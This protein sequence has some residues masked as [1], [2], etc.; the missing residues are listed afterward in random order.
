MIAKIRKKFHKSLEYDKFLF[1]FFP[2]V[3]TIYDTQ[4]IVEAL[5]DRGF[6]S[7]VQN[8]QD[9][10][11]K[12]IVYPTYRSSE[13]Y[14]WN[15][16]VRW[17]YDD[18]LEREINK[19]LDV[20]CGYGTLSLYYQTITACESYLIDFI[21]DYMSKSLISKFSLNF[22]VSNIE[23]EPIPY[24]GIKYDTIIFTEVLEHLNFHPIP[25]L[26]KISSSLKKGGLLYISTPDAAEWGKLSRFYKDYRKMPLPNEKEF[27]PIDNHIYHYNKDELVEILTQTGLEIDRFDYS[28]GYKYSARHFCVVCR[29]N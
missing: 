9:Y 11:G 8:G 10:S 2:W 5:S 26:Q 13:I 21:P 17:L 12:E 27:Q 15:P 4:N 29:K 22:C 14:Y 7:T 20:G 19:T 24:P 28:P 6:Y 18:A 16:I 1:E 23:L 3:K 25:T